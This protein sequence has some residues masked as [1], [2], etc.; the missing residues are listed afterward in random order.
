MITLPE[1]PDDAIL[2]DSGGSLTYGYSDYHMEEYGLACAIAALEAAIEAVGQH[3]RKGREWIPGS[4]WDNLT[5]EA[6][7]RIRAL[8]E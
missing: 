8:I 3:N 4:M 6:V 1:L 5:A 2:D 7:G